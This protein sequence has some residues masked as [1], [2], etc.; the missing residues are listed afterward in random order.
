MAYRYSDTLKWQD[1]WFVDLT[2]LQKLL[3]LYLYDN[4]DIAGFFELSHKKIAF[5]LGCNADEIKGA[6]KGLNK[7]VV[8]SS[9]ERSLLVKN[10]IKHQKNLP[11]NPENKAHQGILKRA[12]LYMAKFP[13]ITLDYQEGYL[14]KGATKPLE[15]GTGININTGILKVS[16]EDREKLFKLSLY[17]FTIYASNQTGIYE[18]DM[19]KKFF[20][21]WREP[22]KSKSKMKFEMEKTWDLKL[23]LSRWSNSPLNA[24]KEK[25]S[26]NQAIPE[27]Q[28]NDQDF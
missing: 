15:R 3:F 20:D 2:T 23:R 5:D 19:V 1:E 12:S 8:V 13:N 27:S 4:C 26:F 11:L 9:D 16:I 25:K 24:V 17:P 18:K 21:Y 6:I 22:N 28:L 7:G 10:F 14:C